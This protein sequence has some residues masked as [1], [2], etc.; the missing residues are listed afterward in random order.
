[1]SDTDLEKCVDIVF[2]RAIILLLKKNSFENTKEFYKFARL[3]DYKNFHKDSSILKLAEDCKSICKVQFILFLD[4]LKEFLFFIFL[5]FICPLFA[6]CVH[7]YIFK[8]SLVFLLLIPLFF[9]CETEYKKNYKES[10]NMYQN[11]ANLMQKI[12]SNDR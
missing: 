12:I 8:S 11:A 10:L 7:F 3:A 2:N 5:C 6:I 4:K 9:L 1:M